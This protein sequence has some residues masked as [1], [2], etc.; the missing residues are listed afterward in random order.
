MTHALYWSLL[1][2][3]KWDALGPN[4]LKYSVCEE[5]GLILCL[6]VDQKTVMWRH[7]AQTNNLLVQIVTWMV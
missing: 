6:A 3:K 7:A 4:Q 1:E 5:D 2:T